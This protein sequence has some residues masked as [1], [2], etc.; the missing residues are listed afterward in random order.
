[1]NS[2]SSILQACVDFGLGRIC[3][4]NDLEL[5]ECPQQLTHHTFCLRAGIY[6]SFLLVAFPHRSCKRWPSTHIWGHT[7]LWR[8][9]AYLCGSENMPRLLAAYYPNCIFQPSVNLSAITFSI[10]RDWMSLVRHFSIRLIISFATN[11]AEGKNI[12]DT[13]P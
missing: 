7:D 3:H 8:V 1:M 2:Q 9:Q 5:S 4:C 13:I 6:I 11:A 12:V 10:S